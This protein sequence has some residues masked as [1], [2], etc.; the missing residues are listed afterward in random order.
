MDNMELTNGTGDF[1]GVNIYGLDSVNIKNL[2]IHNLYSRIIGGL[3]VSDTKYSY[4]EA[5]E[6]NSVIVIG[7]AMRLTN[8]IVG[9]QCQSDIYNLKIQNNEPSTEEP[10]GG[11]MY[12]AG[13]EPYINSMEVNMVNALF[14]N[15]YNNETFW[16]NMGSALAISDYVSLKLVNATSR[17]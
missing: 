17:R 15:N 14:T 8:S 13:K 6:I 16:S 5:I 10:G 12:I 9:T 1:G 4:L 3:R 2:Y 11:G 7:R